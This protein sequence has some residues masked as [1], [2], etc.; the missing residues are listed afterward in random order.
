MRL[1]GIGS[2][3]GSDAHR[4]TEC[5]H[6]HGHAQKPGGAGAQGMALGAA[7]LEAEQKQ[8]DAQLSLSVWLDKTLQSGKR[9]WG[10]IWGSN[11]ESAAGE[12]GDRTGAAQTMAQIGPEN[13]SSASSSQAAPTQITERQIQFNPYFQP[14]EIKQ[15]T[16]VLP[17]QKLRNKVKEVAGILADHLPGKAFHFQTKNGFQ[18]KHQQAKEDLRRQSRYR[19]DEMEIDCIL[20]DEEYLLDSY[21]RK[22]AY[23][24]LTTKK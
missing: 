7:Q 14:L 5:I 12:A 16:H 3:H 22:G 4:V 9:L 19:T 13:A 17:M 11:V 21:D 1:N 15:S 23:S 20:T 8:Q 24:T 18:A 10:R 2:G 6:N